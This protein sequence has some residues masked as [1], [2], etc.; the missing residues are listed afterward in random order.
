MNKISAYDVCRYFFAKKGR[1]IGVN[2]FYT[3]LARWLKPPQN[4]FIARIPATMPKGS[5]TAPM[6]MSDTQSF[7]SERYSGYVSFMNSSIYGGAISYGIKALIDYAF[8]VANALFSGIVIGIKFG[9]FF[10]A[11]AVVLALAF[12][13][14]WLFSR[15]ACLPVTRKPVL[16][17]LSDEK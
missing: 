16:E 3:A 11:L 1:E 2:D 10:L 14:A 8:S 9:Y 13:V 6:V 15:V 7:W 5:M 4:F 17:V 12:F